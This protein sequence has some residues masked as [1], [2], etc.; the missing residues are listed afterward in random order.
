MCMRSLCTPP[1]LPSSPSTQYRPPAEWRGPQ[2][3]LLLPTRHGGRRRGRGRAERR[4]G[5]GG[6]GG[7]QGRG[8]NARRSAAVCT[9]NSTR[10]AA[11]GTGGGGV[12]G[13]WRV[14]GGARGQ[15]E[16]EGK[17][18]VGGDRSAGGRGS[19]P[20]LAGLLEEEG[21]REGRRRGGR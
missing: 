21:W 12:R 6:G 10:P 4:L 1:A 16:E 9:V 5:G 15:E 20:A 3:G 17:H 8:K 18:G 2:Q 19:L 11:S 14:E 7:R 13:G